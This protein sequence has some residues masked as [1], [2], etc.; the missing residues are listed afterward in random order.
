MNI[1]M[2]RYLLLWTLVAGTKVRDKKEIFYDIDLSHSYFTTL[3]PKRKSSFQFYLPAFRF[4]GTLNKKN[5]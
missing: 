1:F 3:N 2:L 4:I 5:S